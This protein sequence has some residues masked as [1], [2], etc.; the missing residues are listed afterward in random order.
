MREL[1]HVV[2]SRS[3]NQ[4]R[5]SYH[6]ELAQT[7]VHRLGCDAFAPFFRGLT[8]GLVQV[9]ERLGHVVQALEVAW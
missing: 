9:V 1:D 2:E 7:D 6:V 8:R 4:L 3:M 5:Y